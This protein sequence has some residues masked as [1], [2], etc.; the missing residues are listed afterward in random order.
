MFSN[1]LVCLFL[2]SIRYICI[3]SDYDFNDPKLIEILQ[4]DPVWLLDIGIYSVAYHTIYISNQNY[5]KCQSWVRDNLFNITISDNAST[6]S[7]SL[8]II[9]PSVQ[10]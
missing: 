1:I 3:V 10:K 8:L 4:D 5:I 9:C 7:E 2:N 6:A